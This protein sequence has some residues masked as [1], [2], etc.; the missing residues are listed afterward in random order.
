MAPSAIAEHPVKDDVLVPKVI[1]I[2]PLLQ[3]DP[4]LEDHRT[5]KPA[6]KFSQAVLL[7]E[8]RFK[9]GSRALKVLVSVLMHVVVITVPILLGLFFTDAINIKQYASMM[10]VAPP[11]PP[12][13]PPLATAPLV[14]VAPVRQRFVTGGKLFAPTVIPKTIAA[15]KEAPLEPESFGVPG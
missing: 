2:I 13:P 14:K 15:I 6:F 11:P 9:T 5:I 3:S 10:L 1:E 12:P 7:D 8:N 4:A